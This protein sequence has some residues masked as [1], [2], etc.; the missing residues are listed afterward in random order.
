VITI[1]IL[2]LI[3]QLE[4][5]VSGGIRVP[6]SVKTAI[7]ENAFF[8][9]IDQM[10]TEIPPAIK[11][12]NELLQQKEKVLAAASEEADRIVAEAQEKA[13]HLVDG[14]EIIAAARAQAETIRAQSQKEAEAIRKGADDY[15]LGTLSDLESRLGS[16]LRT[17]SNGL[18]TLKRRQTQVE[19]G[20]TEETA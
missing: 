7:D 18:T 9:I 20:T 12:A 6:F 19:S 11:Q 15:A 10:R 13:A 16:L 2:A 5:I 1:E 8:D 4:A 14:H 3:D 17:T